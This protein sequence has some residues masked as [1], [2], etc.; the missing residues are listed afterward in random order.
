MN[1]TSAGKIAE[2]KA[3]DWLESQAFE[4]IDHNWRTKVCEIDIIALKNNRI[5]FIEVKYRRSADY[6]VG[7]E[8]ITGKK[9]RRMAFA[10][11][12]WKHTFN[13]NG[14]YTLAAIGMVGAEIDFIEL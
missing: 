4:I 10:A 8:Y 13:W 9:L 1:T 14:D 7:L 11:E 5:Y 2:Q 12:V 3:A 6:G